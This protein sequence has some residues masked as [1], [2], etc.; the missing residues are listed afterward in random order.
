M[1]QVGTDII[2]A[3]TA[4]NTFPEPRLAICLQQAFILGEGKV[5]FEV[6][7]CERFDTLK[8]TSYYGLT[9]Q[10]ND[11][12]TPVGVLIFGKAV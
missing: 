12:D 4:E 11:T 8:V 1:L 3:V 7:R 10:K 2:E 9:Q 6:V 5:L